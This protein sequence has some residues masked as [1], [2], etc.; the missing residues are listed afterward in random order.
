MD[1]RGNRNGL[2][3]AQEQ[4]PRILIVDDHPLICKGYELIIQN[5]IQK[6]TL[7]NFKIE[8]ANSLEAAYELFI[9]P[10]VTFDLVFLDICMNPFREKDIFSGE[11][12]G[13]F[14]IN[15][16]PN[17]KILVMTSL[18]EKIRL[19]GI[20][21]NLR[22]NAFLVKCE[23]NEFHL[24]TAIQYVMNNQF[25][26]SH[27]ISNMLHER[28]VANDC[29]DEEEKEFLYLLSKGYRNK[30]ITNQLHWSLSKVEKRKRALHKK[31]CVEKGT[32]MAL[33]DKAK[34]YG[35]I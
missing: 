17:I 8:I 26:Y 13:K 27:S 31:L 19:K 30:Q 16:Y 14:I 28:S 9:K 22:P 34:E 4:P 7:S 18:T 23:V 6:G 25:Y 1:Y 15:K 21:K 11:D 29:F 10:S 2:D 32:T 33:V 35:I 3:C 24:V 5:G 20:L 12:L